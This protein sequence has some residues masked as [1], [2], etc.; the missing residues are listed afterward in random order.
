IP[1]R[2]EPQKVVHR[3]E[4]HSL[5]HL[6]GAARIYLTWQELDRALADVIG[7]HLA[8]AGSGSGGAKAA[9]AMEYSPLARLPYVSRVDGGTIELV[10]G[11]GVE[12]VSSGDL[13][14]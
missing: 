4:P 13:A 10:R 7:P 12:I 14:Q 8:S 9:I 6:P 3:L 5:G 2:G 11:T 1:A